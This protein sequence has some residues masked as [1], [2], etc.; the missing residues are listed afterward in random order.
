MLLR[1]FFISLVFLHNAKKYSL[2]PYVE[3]LHGLVNYPII[4]LFKGVFLDYC[5]DEPLEFTL[6]L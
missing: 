3:F 6:L 1:N 2:I 4:S 5:S